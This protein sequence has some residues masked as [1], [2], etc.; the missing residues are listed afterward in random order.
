MS[1]IKLRPY[2]QKFI[3][4]VRE[5]FKQGHKNV[6]GVAPCGSGKTIMT[7]WMTRESAQKGNRVLFMVHRHE[8]IEQTSQ[9]FH[10]L[11]IEH[12]IIASGA[13]ARYDLPVQIASVQTLVRRL[14]KIPRPDLLICDECHHILASTYLQIINNWI[15]KPYLLGVTATPLRLGGI[16]L[17]KVFND[18]V[19][20]PSVGKLIDLKNLTRFKYFAPPSQVDTSKLKSKFGEYVTNDMINLMDRH[21]IIGDVI[22]SYKQYVKGKQTIVY[23]V[24]VAHSKHT[25]E[26]FTQAGIIAAHVDGDTP[27]KERKLI[28]EAFRKGKI[29]V[30]CNAELFGEGFDVPNMECVILTRPT[31][32]LTVFIQQ[33]MRPLRPDPKNKNKVA[34]IIDHVQNVDRFGLPDEDR[35]WSLDIN[36]IKKSGITPTKKC[37]ECYEV[38]H[39][40][41]HHCPHCNHEFEFE[42]VKQRKGKVLKQT[43]T[44]DKDYSN[45]RSENLI[46]EAPTFRQIAER[47]LNQSIE[48]GYKKAW[49]Y[50]KVIDYV[51]SE[52]D[53]R[54]LAEV[55]NY[56]RGWAWHKWQN[57]INKDKLKQDE[58]N[59]MNIFI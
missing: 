37:P 26:L 9:T 33:A 32:S 3:D 39:L 44:T 55:L 36:K 50:Y 11:D 8:L 21:E 12:G 20:G 10:D 17:N 28:I 48:C 54:V 19:I 13:K 22:E 59:E 29:T 25:A 30:L 7:G 23:C 4:D 35:L 40:G 27:K 58:P 46:I 56:K 2:Q 49:V 18:M 38:V 53:F 42:Y 34:I 24:N 45:E 51:K 16:T 6:C 1:E 31:K 14:D 5:R 47:F 15:N 52:E 43:D 57:L 41:V